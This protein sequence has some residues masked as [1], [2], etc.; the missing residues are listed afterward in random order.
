MEEKATWNYANNVAGNLCALFAVIGI[1]VSVVLDFLQTNISTTIIIFFIYSI[2]TIF[3][4]LVLPVKMS[5]K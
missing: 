3:V 1:I 4:V 5:K 2:T